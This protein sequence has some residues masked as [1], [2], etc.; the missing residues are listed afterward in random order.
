VLFLLVFIQYVLMFFL[1]CQ[2]LQDTPH[3]LTHP[4]LC[5][6]SQNK[7]NQQKTIKNKNKQTYQKPTKQKNKET[8]RNHEVGFVLAHYS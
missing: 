1:L 3:F 5:A 7:K 4:T 6:V 2:L 8:N